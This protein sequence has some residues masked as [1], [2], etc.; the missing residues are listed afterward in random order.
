[1]EFF[2][3]G[4][5]SEKPIDGKKEPAKVV[6]LY[7]KVVSRKGEN[8]GKAQGTSSRLSGDQLARNVWGERAGLKGTGG[9]KRGYRIRRTLISRFFLGGGEGR[10]QGDWGLP[11]GGH[12]EPLWEFLNGN[13]MRK[14][15][16][17]RGGGAG[18]AENRGKRGTGLSLKLGETKVG[19]GAK[20]GKG[21]GGVILGGLEVT[22]APSRDAT[23]RKG[24]RKTEEE[25]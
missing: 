21:K 10:R 23:W 9:K 11:G 3:E 12:L 24:P 18:E 22:Q 5:G 4:K 14:K 25:S 13:R 16:G 2:K 15:V 17:G 7:M 8:Q 19:E 20:F 1:M 6:S